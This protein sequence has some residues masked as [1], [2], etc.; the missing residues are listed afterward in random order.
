MVLV[1]ISPIIHGQYISWNY[2][3]AG[4][5]SMTLGY[6]AH[7]QRY[8]C[9]L[10]TALLCTLRVNAQSVS[11]IAAPEM[12][13]F[14]L[15][16]GSNTALPGFPE[17]AIGFTGGGYIQPVSPIG[18]EFRASSFLISARFP[19]SPVTVGLRVAPE[20]HDFV[21]IGYLGAGLSRS[22]DIGTT[23]R[24]VLPAQWVPAWQGSVGLDRKFSEVSW[25]V[26]DV[27]YIRATTSK[28]SLRTGTIGTGIVFRFSRRPWR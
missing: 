16:S 10:F 17:N 25:R 19:Q 24:M 7:W 14:I 28:H 21:A 13:F 20:Y 1:I 11:P 6:K 27:S 5:S 8:I 22:T 26:V 15:E 4:T 3:S 12:G 18:F 9:C 2:R 23:S